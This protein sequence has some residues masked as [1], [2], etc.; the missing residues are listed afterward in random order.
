M[1]LLA[2]GA[3]YKLF[4]EVPQQLADDWSRQFKYGSIGAESEEGIPYWIFY[5]LP[6]M[7]PEKLPGPG[8]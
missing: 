1:A 3:W 2:F 4:R 5:V 7:F 6:E 8:G